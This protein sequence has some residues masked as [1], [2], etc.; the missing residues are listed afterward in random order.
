LAVRF[1]D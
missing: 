1:E